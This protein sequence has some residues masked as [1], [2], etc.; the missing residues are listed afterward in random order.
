MGLRKTRSSTNP[1]VNA[2]AREKRTLFQTANQTESQLLV[3]TTST[4]RVFTLYSSRGL[5]GGPPI[6]FPLKLYCPLWHAHQICLVSSRY[7][8]MHSR[9]VHTAENALNSPV[10]V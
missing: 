1:G 5:G 10:A 8:T 6:F 2:W 3:T 7:W 4:P 9:C